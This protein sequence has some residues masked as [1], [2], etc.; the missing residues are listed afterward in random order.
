MFNTWLDLNYAFNFKNKRKLK[1]ISIKSFKNYF[2]CHCLHLICWCTVLAF[3]FM[4]IYHL[5]K[6]KDILIYLGDTIINHIV[7]N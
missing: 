4:H 2:Q 7:W 6:S 3:Y 5:S 1:L